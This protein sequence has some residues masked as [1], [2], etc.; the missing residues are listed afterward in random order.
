M[1][2]H[3]ML[4]QAWKQVPGPEGMGLGACLAP[5]ASLAWMPLQ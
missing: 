3:S 2:P 4:E 5:C 1:N